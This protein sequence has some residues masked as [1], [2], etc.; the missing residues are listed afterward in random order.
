MEKIQPAIDP[1]PVGILDFA[2]AVLTDYAPAWP[3]GREWPS[4]DGAHFK[5]DA[6]A[7]L[8]RALRQLTERLE[9]AKP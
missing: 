7:H 3:A 2:R 9:E 6:A 1:A 5:G 8:Y 4:L